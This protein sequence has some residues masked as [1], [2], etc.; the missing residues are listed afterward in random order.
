MLTNQILPRWAVKNIKKIHSLTLFQNLNSA[1]L[2]IKL[3]MKRHITT[4]ISFYNVQRIPIKVNYPRWPKVGPLFSRRFINMYI[5]PFDILNLYFF[6][7]ISVTVLSPCAFSVWRPQPVS[8]FEPS[9]CAYTG[10]TASQPVRIRPWWPLHSTPTPPHQLPGTG[11]SAT[12]PPTPSLGG[13]PQSPWEPS[14]PLSTRNMNMNK[15]ILEPVY[16]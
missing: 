15:T 8:G 12:H 14:H 10:G 7:Q 11:R 13:G 3:V 2:Y 1:F 4:H 16:N 5:T 9:A 6:F